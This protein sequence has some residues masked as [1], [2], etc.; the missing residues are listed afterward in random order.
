MSDEI[1]VGV[2]HA[3][4]KLI[5]RFGTQ[6]EVIAELRHVLALIDKEAV[7]ASSSAVEAAVESHEEAAVSPSTEAEPPPQTLHKRSTGRKK[8]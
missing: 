2:Q 6:G 5:N 1:R 3:I 4:S 8:K 7:P